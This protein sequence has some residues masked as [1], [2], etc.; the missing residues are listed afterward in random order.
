MKPIVVMERATSPTGARF[1]QTVPMMRNVVVGRLRD[2]PDEEATRQDGERL[3]R[4]LAGIAALD[5]PG[6][7]DCR[8]GRDAGVRE[9]GWSFAITNDFVDVDA[10]RLYDADEEHGR[11]R[12]VLVEVSDQ[13]ARVQF[14]I[15]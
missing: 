7:L 6:L 4:A 3:E 12:Q 1:L 10:Y 13:L 14:E 2:A 11:H 15:A 9:G 8:V 5:L